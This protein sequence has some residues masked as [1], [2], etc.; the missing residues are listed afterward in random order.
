MQHAISSL[1]S[2]QYI[3]DCI[4]KE[5]Q[6]LLIVKQ[7]LDLI[8]AQ[9]DQFI[10]PIFQM[11]QVKKTMTSNNTVSIWD[12]KETYTIKI[13]SAKNVNVAENQK[14]YV[15][16]SIYHG[17]E[18]VCDSVVTSL[19]AN[20]E[21]AEWNEVLEFNIPVRE[22]PRAAKLCFVI[23]SRRQRWVRKA[24]KEKVGERGLN[25]TSDKGV[26]DYWN[27]GVFITFANFS[28]IGKVWVL[29]LRGR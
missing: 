4:A 12:L 19:G 23:F 11:A 1:I 13:L 17:C 18:P 2:M 14:V 25:I 3:R 9:K 28:S 7:F 16:A 6:P 5:K 26:G 29:F 22:I 8:P 20:P 24:G 10:P 27:L 15:R 21:A